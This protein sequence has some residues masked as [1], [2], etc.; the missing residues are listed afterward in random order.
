MGRRSTWIGVFAAGLIGSGAIA[1]ESADPHAR[2]WTSLQDMHAEYVKAFVQSDGFGIRRVTPMMMLVQGGTVTLDGRR[3]RVEDVQLIG[4]AKHDPPVVYPGGFLEFQHGDKDRA[5][6]P[7]P[8]TRPV[9][10]QERRILTSL[11]QGEEVVSRAR[12]NGIA[13]VGAIRATESCLQCHR[14][15]QVGDLLGAFVYSLAPAQQEQAQS[16]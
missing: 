11:Q 7:L 3:L 15:K 12:I 5:F 10:E 8:A 6:L 16:P 9:D 14:N 13:A 1:A 4:I 2:T